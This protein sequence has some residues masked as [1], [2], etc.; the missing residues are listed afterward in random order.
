MTADSDDALPMQDDGDPVAGDDTPED[1]TPE[2]DASRDDDSLI[3][4]MR[5]SGAGL[6]DP[7][8]VGDPEPGLVEEQAAED[9][10]PQV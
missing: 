4:R 6:A 9:E 3:D 10:P 2:D 1:D 5:D 8:I 7:N